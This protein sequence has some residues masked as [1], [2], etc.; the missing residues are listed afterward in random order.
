MLEAV[1]FAHSKRVIHC[2]IKPDNFIIFPGE[3]LRLTDFGIAKITSHYTMSA[4][5][6]GTLGYMAPEQAM[7][8]PSL[9]SDVFSLGLIIWRMFT[10]KLPKW[11]YQ[12]PLPGYERLRH[13]VHPDFIA[14]LRRS[15]EVD[16]R[17]RFPSAVKMLTTFRRLRPRME[18]QRRRRRRRKR[19]EKNG[20]LYLKQLEFR[21]FRRRYNRLLQ[22]FFD[23][24]RCGGP[25]SEAMKCCPWCGH[26]TKTFRHETRF[27]ARCRYCRRGMKLDWRFCPHCYGALQG[28]RSRRHYTDVRYEATCPECKGE[29]M[30]FMRYCPWCRAK[31]RRKWRMEGSVHRCTRC[32][33]GILPDFWSLCPWCGTVIR[34]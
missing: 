29:L 10:G 24:R 9:H 21:E 7:G 28:P 3:R 8:K 6:S 20:L 33:W 22:L 17:K 14:F 12:W 31:V 34:R 19:D 5:G 25:I 16:V 32:G 27:P 13:R 11:P 23:C 2:D 15:L 26:E 30:R 1:A 4:S 18:R